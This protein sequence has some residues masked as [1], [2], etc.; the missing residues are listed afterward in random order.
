MEDRTKRDTTTRDRRRSAGDTGDAAHLAGPRPHC[1]LAADLH[2]IGGAIC[3]PRA[4]CPKGTS[5]GPTVC[6]RPQ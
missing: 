5:W 2:G 6:S 1:Q 3:L 4:L